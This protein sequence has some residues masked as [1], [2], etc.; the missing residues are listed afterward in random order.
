MTI[1]NLPYIVVCVAMG[2]LGGWYGALGHSL[3]VKLKKDVTA[4]SLWSLHMP[5]ILPSMQV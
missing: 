1:Y 5:Q 4:K 2:L 3:L